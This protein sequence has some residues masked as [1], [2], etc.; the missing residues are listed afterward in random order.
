RWRAPAHRLR[1]AGRLWMSPVPVWILSAAAL[2][3]WHVP[4][5]YDRALEF[6]PLHVVEHATYLGTSVAFWSIAIRRNR[7]LEP[8]W[9]ALYVMSAALP[10]AA[11][12]AL[13]I[14]ASRPLYPYYGGHPGALADQQLGGLLMWLPPLVV[15]LIGASVLFVRWVDHADTAGRRMTVM[16]VG[17]LAVLLLAGA[18]AGCGSGQRA[19]P[20][21]VPGGIPDQGAAAIGHYNCG[22]CHEIPGIGGAHGLVG[23][24]LWKFK[25]RSFI[26]GELSNTPENLMRWLRDP[27]G[28]EPGTDM[29]NL[30]VTER[31]ARDITAY[32]YT[33]K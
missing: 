22:S 23:P 29:P 14:F 10:G 20:S 11:L 28:V 26:A 33:L 7:G 17:A 21:E 13:L 12:G 27:K 32:L 31:D 5:I 24:P 3:I 19:A 1:R 2:W 6:A 8:G 25:R 4:A 18:L 16:A 15:Y 9:G 30:G